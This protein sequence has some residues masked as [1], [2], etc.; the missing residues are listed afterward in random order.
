MIFKHQQI[1]ASNQNFQFQTDG[2]LENKKGRL[3]DLQNGLFDFK[4]L[5]VLK[6]QL[7]PFLLFLPQLILLL[8]CVP[9]QPCLWH[10]DRGQRVR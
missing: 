3:A 10:L 6:P 2:S 8:P 9:G 1:E 7:Q 5:K 4:M